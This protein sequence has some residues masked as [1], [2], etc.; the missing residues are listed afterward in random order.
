MA[1][2]RDEPPPLWP[3]HWFLIIVTSMICQYGFHRYS[4]PDVTLW[5]TTPAD[6][7]LVTQQPLCFDSDEFEALRS[8]AAK[9]PKLA[10]GAQTNALTTAFKGTAGVFVQFTESGYAE[11]LADSKL[12][13]F[14]AFVDAMRDGS[15]ANAFVLNVV[16]ASPNGDGDVIEY[17][18]DQSLGLSWIQPPGHLVANLVDVLYLEVP[19]GLSGGELE[20]Q[21]LPDEWLDQHGLRARGAFRRARGNDTAGRL[22]ASVTPAENTRVTFRGDAHHRVRNFT[23]SDESAR[24]V[25]LVL[26]SYVLSSW[27]LWRAFRF[28]VE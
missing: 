15:S 19:E 21:K 17:H 16:S 2:K 22:D 11:L 23:A 24:R 28:Y 26:E 12:E 8:C 1:N 9:H 13:C 7:P 14:S 5:R 25:S 6:A 4:D 3:T 18:M 10:A 27:Y 20:V